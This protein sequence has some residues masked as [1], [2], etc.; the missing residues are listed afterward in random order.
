MLAS[1]LDG[2]LIPPDEGE[3]RR[4]EIDHFRKVVEAMA[5]RLA[6]VTGRHLPLALEG[7]SR[8]DLPRPLALAC[9][10]GTAVFWR[11]GATYVPDA[12]YRDALASSPDVVPADRV[13]VELAGV[14]GLHAQAAEQQGEFKV[15]YYL[16]RG[17]GP[18]AVAEVR[19]RLGDLGRVRLVESHDPVTGDLL[20]D[21]LPENVGKAGAVR[22]VALCMDVDPGAV[23]FAG[24]SGNDRDAIL[25]GVNAILVGNA[26]APLRTALRREVGERGLAD[27]VFF[28]SEHFAAGVVQ[29]LRHF[30][31]TAR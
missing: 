13:R 28:A 22:Y 15:S 24:D 20:L 23:V 29:G 21:V 16:D 4:R 11:R 25:S 9:D 17:A 2:T 19:R 8:C 1:D 26:P 30:G 7:I 6:Y 18:S 5:L 27:R 10:V 12:G 31:R 14:P 3:D